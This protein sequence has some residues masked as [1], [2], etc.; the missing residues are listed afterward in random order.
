MS[1][2]RP[3]HFLPPFLTGSPQAY[4][5]VYPQPMKIKTAQIERLA[6]HILK[7][8]RS[9]DLLIL[10]TKEADIGAKIRDIIAQNFHQEE[11]I[12]EEARKMLASHADEVKEMD[13]YKM[14]LLLKQKLAEKRGFVL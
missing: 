7:N 1:S 10:K 14:F 5:Q 6:D 8:Y 11:T 13:H 9:K 4:P 3:K 12:E 2:E